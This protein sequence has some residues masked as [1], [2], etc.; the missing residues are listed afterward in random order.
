MKS[1]LHLPST[2][3]LEE[4]EDDEACLAVSRSVRMAAELFCVEEGKF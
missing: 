1:K 2:N 3:A 4:S